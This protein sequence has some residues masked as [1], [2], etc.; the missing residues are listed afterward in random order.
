MGTVGVVGV[1]GETTVTGGELSVDWVVVVVDVVDVVGR[2][3]GCGR[4]I[5]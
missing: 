1:V 2:K 5:T 4:F 3:R